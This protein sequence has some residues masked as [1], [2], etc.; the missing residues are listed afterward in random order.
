MELVSVLLVKGLE[1]YTI[2]TLLHKKCTLDIAL[3]NTIKTIMIMSNKSNSVLASVGRGIKQAARW[4]AK[5]FGYKAENKYAR[6]VW[7]VFAT[8]AAIFALIFVTA[9]VFDVVDLV[10]DLCE[11]AKYERMVNSSTYL[12]DYCNQ[13]VSP[14]VIYHDDLPGYQYNTTLGQRTATG[15]QWICKSS[16]GDSLACFCTV[17]E[18]KRGYFNRFTG[19]VAIPAQYDKAWIFSE[20]VACVLDKGVLH[21]IDHKGQTLMGKV[22][23]YTERIDDYCFHNGLC[24]MLGD[25]N[26]IGLI[27]K[28]GSWVV[29]PEYYEMAYDT[30]GFWLV[31]ARDWNYGLLDA[32]GQML[33]PVEYDNITVHHEDSCIFVRRLDHLNQVLDF[34]CNIINPCNFVEVEKMEYSTDEYDEEGVMKS[35]TAK[36]LRYRTIDWNYGLMDKNGNMITPPSYSSIVSIGYDRYHCDGPNGSVILDSKGNEC[37]EKL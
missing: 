20:G 36:C 37:G 21:F 6:G 2:K 9:L 17:E 7:Y 18:H 14:Y 31:Q 15:V 10:K 35:A 23:P 32:K 3:L 26:C 1:N 33:L 28:Q 4:V 34:E 5:M 25:N 12:H 13:Y 27:D 30:K 24:Q 11:D 22:F 8:S 19:E 29:S 16:D